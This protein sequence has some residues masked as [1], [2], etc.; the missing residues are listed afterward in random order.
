M[1]FAAHSERDAVGQIVSLSSAFLPVRPEALEGANGATTSRYNG[2]MPTRGV[3]LV[4]AGLFVVYLVVVIGLMLLIHPRIWG[5]AA[6]DA[7]VVAS[8][9]V[10]GVPL[11]ATAAGVRAS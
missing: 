11:A 7:G 2:A 1:A 10:L 4:C 5:D 8:V 3:R 6:R 9:F